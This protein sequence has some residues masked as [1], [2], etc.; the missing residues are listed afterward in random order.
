MV[1]MANKFPAD[2]LCVVK[3]LLP[4]PFSSFWVT[5]KK[6]KTFLWDTLYISRRFLSFLLSKLGPTDVFLPGPRITLRNPILW[7]NSLKTI[8]FYYAYFC[9]N[10]KSWL[11]IMNSFWWKKSQNKI[12]FVT[13]Y[14]E[15]FLNIRCGRFHSWILHQVEDLVSTKLIFS[16]KKG[17]TDRIIKGRPHS[18]YLHFWDESYQKILVICSTEILPQIKCFQWAKV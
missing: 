2:C 12:F 9:N 4:Y 17:V 15:C 7:A 6:K 13:R 16:W 5:K 18:C 1:L 11:I 10:L 14:E 3:L 8:M